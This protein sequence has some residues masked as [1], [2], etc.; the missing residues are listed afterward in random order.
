[1]QDFKMQIAAMKKQAEEILESK[2][3]GKWLGITESSLPTDYK[4]CKRDFLTLRI[5]WK[6]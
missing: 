6:K 5:Q 3:L 2:N 1:M 4:R